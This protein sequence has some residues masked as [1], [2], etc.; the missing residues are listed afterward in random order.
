M[1]FKSKGK[2]QAAMRPASSQSEVS[3]V[4]AMD[5]GRDTKYLPKLAHAPLKGIQPNSQGKLAPPPIFKADAK[6]GRA[7]PQRAA[8][9]HVNKLA[10]ELDELEIGNE[11]DSIVIIPNKQARQA[12]VMHGGPNAEYVPQGSEVDTGKKKKRYVL[13]IC[14]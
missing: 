8:S 4:D 13:L 1:P 5:I 9:A 3:D 6:A 10:Q 11:D 12:A 2:K 7:K 14:G